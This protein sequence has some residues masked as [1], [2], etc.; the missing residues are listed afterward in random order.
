MSLRINE[1]VPNFHAV[2]DQ[3]EI[4]FHDFIG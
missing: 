2:T 4:D 1:T 3:G